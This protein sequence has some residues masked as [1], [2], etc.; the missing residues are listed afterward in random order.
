MS[1]KDSEKA[2]DN[3]NP[4]IRS[5]LEI[6]IKR[7][8]DFQTKT[9]PKSWVDKTGEI[10]E[11]VIPIDSIGAYIPGGT[12]PLLSTVIM[13]LIPAKVAGVKRTVVFTPSTEKP[14]M[15][16]IIACAE[17]IGA[18]EIYNIGGAQAIAASA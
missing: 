2:L 12:A 10:G 4:E 5:A 18:S 14:S 7:I 11:N 16:P 13:T 6:S 9:L 17:L 8:Y 1:K 15:N 3:L